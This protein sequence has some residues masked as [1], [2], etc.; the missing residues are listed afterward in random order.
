MTAGVKIWSQTAATNATASSAVNW[1]EGQAPSTVNDSARGMMADVAK[2]RDDLAGA[3]TTGGTSTAYTLTTNQVFASLSEMSGQAIR[4]KFSATN[5]ASPTLNVD[6]LNAKALVTVTGTA[7]GAGKIKA[8]AVYDVVYANGSSEFILINGTG[9]DAAF[10]AGTALIFF[11][12]AA[13]TGWTKSSANNDKAIRIVSGT[14]GGTGGSTAFSTIFAARTISQANLPNVSL[15]SSSLTAAATTAGQTS[16]CPG[17]GASTSAFT[18]S[19]GSTLY[20]A[21]TFASVSVAVGGTVPLGGS[22]TAVDFA[23]AYMDCIV[24]T[25]D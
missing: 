13:P 9:V 18:P 5:G 7:V 11:Q 2:W 15:V 8:N 3:L 20:A 24:A 4:V 1:A 14:G 17:T 19:G 10:P 22:G 21:N 23:V 25:K 16:I 6:G 12:A